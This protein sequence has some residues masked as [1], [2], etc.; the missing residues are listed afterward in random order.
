MRS[1]MFWKNIVA[2]QFLVVA[3]IAAKVFESYFI[4]QGWMAGLAAIFNVA[5]G[6]L[7]GTYNQRSIGWQ[8]L[9]FVWKWLAS[10]NTFLLYLIFIL[11]TAEIDRQIREL[12]LL[13]TFP[14]WLCVAL[15]F[16]PSANGEN[17]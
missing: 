16:I 3:P 4:N 12:I 10:V 9:Q 6:L 5:I 2:I 17:S 1:T 7:V 15:I 13:T 8:R 14:G 11:V